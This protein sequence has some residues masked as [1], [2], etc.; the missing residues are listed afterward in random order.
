MADRHSSLDYYANPAPGRGSGV[1]ERVG[2]V[3]PGA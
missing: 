2:A 1:E 3:E